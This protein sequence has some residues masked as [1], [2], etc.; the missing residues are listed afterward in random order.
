MSNEEKPNSMP[1]KPETAAE[2]VP[3]KEA[4]LSIIQNAFEGV[5]PSVHREVSDE[6]GLVLL[7]S[8][9]ETAPG[10]VTEYRYVRKGMHTVLGADGLGRHVGSINN[11]IRVAYYENDIPVGGTTYAVYDEQDGTWKILP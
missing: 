1:A 3:T 4:I 10:E 2:S 11:D 7:E 6:K 8:R 5:E 9:R